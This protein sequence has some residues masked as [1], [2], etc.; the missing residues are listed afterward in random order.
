MANLFLIRELCEER[1]ITLRE[2]CKR[3]DKDESTIQSAIRRGSTNSGTLEDIAEVL[4]VPAG[5]FF[6]GFPGGKDVERYK[7]QVEHLKELLAEK[8]RTITLLM[9]DR[10]R[11]QTQ[12]NT[13]EQ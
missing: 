12:E 5:Y 2:L 1:K 4:G 13:K 3:I 11:M 6:D 8:E 9:E 10:K 7:E